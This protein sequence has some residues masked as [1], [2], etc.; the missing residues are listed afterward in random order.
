MIINKSWAIPS[1]NTFSI[2][3]IN[4]LIRRYKEDTSTSVDIFARNNRLATFTNDLNPNTEAEYHL[5]A[6]DFVEVLKAQNVKADLILFDPPYSP[7]Q[8][9][10]CY[11]SVGKKVTA[12]DTSAAFYSD[13]KDAILSICHIGTIVMSFGWNSTGM[14]AKRGFEQI[15]ILLVNHGGSHND[16]I[17]TVE[18]FTKQ[19]IDLFDYVHP[20]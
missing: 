19:Q 18:Q 7:R 11:Q 12:K 13:I 16:T 6:I 14:G 2:T 8:V 20:N 10:E 5:D 1:H 3:P 9:S 4:N 15:E 17:C